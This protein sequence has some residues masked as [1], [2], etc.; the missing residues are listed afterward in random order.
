MGD[1]DQHRAANMGASK[2]RTPDQ[3]THP[4]MFR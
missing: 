3:G 1:T 4:K 2:S